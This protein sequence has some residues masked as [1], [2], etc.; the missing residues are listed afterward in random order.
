[1]ESCI[2]DRTTRKSVE[3][4]KLRGLDQLALEIKTTTN[5]SNLKDIREI[6]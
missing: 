6:E 4:T 2:I 3:T 1:M 5:S